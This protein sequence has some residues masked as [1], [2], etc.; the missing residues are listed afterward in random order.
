ML[1]VLCATVPAAVAMADVGSQSIDLDRDGTPETLQV[2]ETECFSAEGTATPPCPEDSFSAK[3]ATVEAYCADGRP[4]RID[5]LR[6]DHDAFVAA[7]PVEADGD[8]ATQ[9]VFVVGRS[10]AAARN[11]EDRIVA[12]RRGADGCLAVRTL[13]RHPGKGF[14]TRRPK[15]AS[16]PGTGDAVLSKDGTTLTLEQPW[17]KR[18]DGGCCPTYLAVARFRYSA[19]AGRFVKVSERVKKYDRRG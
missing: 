3:Q 17:Y 11:G 4:Q 14:E 16:Y 19:R 1:A 10:G 12:F 15:R 9:E 13:Y 18:T 7:D 2:R 6:R 5:L 8:P